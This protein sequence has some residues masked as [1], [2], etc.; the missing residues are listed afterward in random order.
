MIQ[1]K[2]C[3]AVLISQRDEKSVMANGSG[4]LCS[5]IQLSLLTAARGAS[6]AVFTYRSAAAAGR[7]VTRSDSVHGVQKLRARK[8]RKPPELLSRQPRTAP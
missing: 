4:V 3:M 1:T 6:H 8:Q 5:R 2:G 7:S